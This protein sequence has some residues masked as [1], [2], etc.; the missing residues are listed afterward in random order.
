MRKRPGGIYEIRH[1]ASGRRY[2]GSTTCFAQRWCNHRKALRSG[3]HYSAF[4]QRSWNKYGE[5][6]FVFDVLE[7]IDDSSI[8][9]TREQEWLDHE[10]PEFNTA[11]CAEAPR[12]GSKMTPAQ[13]RRHSAAMKKAAPKISASLR[14]RRTGPRSLEVRKKISAALMG[15]RVT[16]AQIAKQKRS[17][18]KS[19]YKHSAAIKAQ[20]GKASRE[21]KRTS[22]TR[23]RQ[24]AS[25]RAWWAERKKREAADA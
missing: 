8:L 24:S 1:V 2:I 20:I 21:R 11:T 16:K 4:L 12:R 5:Q 22:E 6:A 13:R 17:Y 19:G 14:G 23:V 25:I 15:H 18:K 3:E 7:K 10:K 9:L